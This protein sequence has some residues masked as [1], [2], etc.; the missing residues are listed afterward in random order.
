MASK[1]TIVV[2]GATGAQ[3]GSVI[4]YLLKEGQNF[5][6]RA[7]TR[8]ASSEKAQ[9]LAAKGI[10][11]VEGDLT[12]PETLGAA[13]NGAYGAFLVTNFWEPQSKSELEQAT[14]AVE[15]AKAA[16]IQHLIWSSLPNCREIS[17]GK[18]EVIHFTAKAEVEKLIEAAG[19]P[20]TT[21]VEAAFYF[22]NLLGLLK[23]QPQEDGSLAWTFNLDPSRTVLH[24]ADITEYGKVAARAFAHPSQ[25]GSGTHLAACGPAISFNSIVEVLRANGNNVKVNQVP[26][27][28]LASFGF[29]GAKELAEMFQW[30]NDY[31]YMG[32]DA[33][34]KIS[35]TAAL[36][37]EGFTSFADW[38][39]KAPIKY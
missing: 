31:T 15:A 2:F 30:F 23:P 32:P 33:D 4:D 37:P 20:H 3:G 13:L 18:L 24:A 21:Y 11:V 12:K 28:V 25:V 17:N 35:A 19:F 6:V 39:A 10:T 26:Q 29:P 7:V 14:A 8:S 36:V 9:A 5:D 38:N 16:G 22:Q 34:K 1:Q 27:D